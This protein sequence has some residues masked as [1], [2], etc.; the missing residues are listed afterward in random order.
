MN[1]YLAIFAAFLAA[2]CVFMGVAI[3]SLTQEKNRLKSNQTA[4]LDSVETYHSKTGKLAASCQAL[5]LTNQELRESRAD[6]EQA[7]KDLGV[8][9]KRA[10]AI[11]QTA[12]ETKVEVRTEVRDSIVYRDTSLV[13]LQAINWADPWIT[14]RG[15]I[16]SQRVSLAVQ[17]RDTLTQVI[18]RVPKRFLGIPYGCKAIRQEIRSSNPHTVI[19]Y[20]E[21]IELPK[22]RKR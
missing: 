4:L 14:V 22:N 18:H 21:Y 11:A 17:S 13:R 1:K 12:T 10:E 2:T 9:L 3:R 20:T 5:E 16:E 7:I 19:T 15:E 6:L 8:K